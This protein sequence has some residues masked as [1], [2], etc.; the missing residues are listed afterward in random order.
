MTEWSNCELVFNLSDGRITDQTTP[1]AGPESLL[2]QAV[3]EQG[4]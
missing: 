2:A 3:P 1:A 4:Q